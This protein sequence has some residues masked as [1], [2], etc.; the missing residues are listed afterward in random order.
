MIEKMTMFMMMM[1][2]LIKMI[3]FPLTG[4]Y[5][6]LMFTPYGDFGLPFFFCSFFLF[7]F[8]VLI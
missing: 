5:W 6:E 7:F 4:N 3:D 2:W 8:F 1:I